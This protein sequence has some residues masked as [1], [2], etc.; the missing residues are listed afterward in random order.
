M[1]RVRA[2]HPNAGLVM[3][4]SGSLESDL[5]A[6][7]AAAPYAEHLLLPGDVRHPATLRAIRECSMLLRTTHYD[8]DAISVREALEMGTPV[9]AT[10]NGMR[11]PGC[12]RIPSPS[13]EPLLDAIEAVLGGGSREPVPSP[14]TSNLDAVLDVYARL[15]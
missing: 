5:R 7:I 3:I 15:L 2:R 9:I 13:M 11:P 8:G 10:D 1:G 12:H 6:R 4:G 14:G